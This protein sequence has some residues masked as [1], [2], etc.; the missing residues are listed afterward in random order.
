MIFKSGFCKT[1][2][3]LPKW[4]SVSAITEVTFGWVTLGFTYFHIPKKWHRLVLSDDSIFWEP[5]QN[6][7]CINI[8]IYIYIWLI[9]TTL[10]YLISC[11]WNISVRNHIIADRV[12]FANIMEIANG[13]ISACHMWGCHL[14]WSLVH[15]Q[16]SF[17]PIWMIRRD[18]EHRHSLRNI[19]L[20]NR[21][22]EQS[23]WLVQE[24]LNSAAYS[25]ELRLTF[26]K[27]SISLLRNRRQYQLTSKQWRSDTINIPW[28]I[29]A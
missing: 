27:P 25:L 19:M 17:I 9:L 26:N 12:V 3:I 22:M 16:Y 13:S 18:F 4:F 21:Y 2:R 29:Y 24:R 6:L 5:Q 10:E 20:R 23:D 14:M 11:L 7:N 1:I 28:E 15:G 8:Y